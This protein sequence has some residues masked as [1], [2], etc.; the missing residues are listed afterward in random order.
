LETKNV[1]TIDPTPIWTPAIPIVLDTSQA[2]GDSGVI[3]NVFLY[4]S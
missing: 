3:S 2:E 1:V 4:C